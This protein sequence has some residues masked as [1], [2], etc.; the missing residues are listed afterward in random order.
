MTP[1]T[2]NTRLFIQRL[3]TNLKEHPTLLPDQQVTSKLDE[4][5]IQFASTIK[6]GTQVKQ[7][8]QLILASGLFQFDEWASHIKGNKTVVKNTMKK[9]AL[10]HIAQSLATQNIRGEYGREAIFS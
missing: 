2:I 5:L 9:L 6:K 10:Q 7:I 1:Q 3:Q 4:A 8:P